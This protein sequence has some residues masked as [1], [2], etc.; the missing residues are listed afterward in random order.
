MFSE[1]LLIRK[2]KKNDSIKICIIFEFFFIFLYILYILLY[3]SIYLYWGAT[4]VAHN[5]IQY[6]YL[7]R[8]QQECGDGATA[9][10][11]L[12]ASTIARRWLDW[13]N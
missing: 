12:I 11:A 2:I 3:I 5:L 4:G 6:T 7:V 13:K 10:T 9:P 1:I 8:L